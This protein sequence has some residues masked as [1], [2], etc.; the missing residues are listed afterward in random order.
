M[1]E[2]IIQFFMWWI[3]CVNFISWRFMYEWTWSIVF[4]H[5]FSKCF[6]GDR[7]FTANVVY[8]ADCFFVIDWSWQ[9]WNDIFHIAECS[10]LWSVAKNSQGLSLH[11][12]IDEYSHNVSECIAN[13]LAGSH[14]VVWSEYCV[15]QSEQLSCVMKVLF[16]SVFRSSIWIFRAGLH[17]FSV[18]NLLRSIRRHAWSENK[19]L[20]L[21]F[22]GV[23]DQVYWLN[24]IVFVVEQANEM[25]QSFSCVCWQVKQIIRRKFF[26]IGFNSFEVW[27]FCKIDIHKVKHWIVHMMIDIAGESS[28]KIIETYNFVSLIK[29]VI[30]QMW[31]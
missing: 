5:F 9:I 6:Y 19:T 16:N 11:S 29:Q 22:H 1:S 7:C 27:F 2:V 13:M 14:Y 12:L 10:C 21:V 18:W 17:V 26:E 31:S 28:W 15:W 25:W 4:N 23:V 30:D 3:R 20:H 8:L 24:Q